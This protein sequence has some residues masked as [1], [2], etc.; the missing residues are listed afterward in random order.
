M[1]VKNYY[2]VLACKQ[3]DS[4]ETLRKAFRQLA[5]KHHPDLNPGDKT[6]EAKMRE[7]AEAW[8]TLGDTEKR[9]Q[10]DLE[11]SGG[12][13]QKPFTAG[14][15]TAPQSSRPMTQEDFFN[16]TRNF[17]GMFSEESI[18]NSAAKIKSSQ[19]N[20]MNP[21]DTTAF[22]EQFMGIKKPKK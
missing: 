5:K 14:P 20:P 4:E 13:K 6:A 3:T 8:E 9:K 19:P 15:G 21:M 10:Y 12:A 17:D 11:L 16:M 7:I 1:A 2:A 18:R 22:F